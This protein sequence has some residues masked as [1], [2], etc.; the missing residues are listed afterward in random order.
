MG[1]FTRLALTTLHS[2]IGVFAYVNMPSR[3]KGTSLLP[4]TA[5]CIYP[6]NRC[7]PNRERLSKEGLGIGKRQAV[8]G[9]VLGQRSDV[10]I[11]QTV[12]AKCSKQIVY[13]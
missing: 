9:G 13:G 3:R 2:V 12:A 6:Q 5:T 1:Q 8:D 4:T 11:A 10:E 7:A